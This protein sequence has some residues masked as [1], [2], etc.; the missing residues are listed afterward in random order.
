[1]SKPRSPEYLAGL[2]AKRKAERIARRARMNAL[3]A[4]SRAALDSVPPAHVEPIN[5]MTS[6]EIR[7]KI[8]A[9]QLVARLERMAMGE[10]PVMSAD[11]I[12]AASILLAKCVP[13]VNRTEIAGVPDQPLEIVERV[14]A[15]LGDLVAQ[16]DHVN[17]SQAYAS[18]LGLKH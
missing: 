3:K 16:D 15:R 14:S 11:Q 6:E 13:D 7:R 1:M 8:R 17:A 9:G 10:G 4:A 12:R 2:Q 18:L 5:R